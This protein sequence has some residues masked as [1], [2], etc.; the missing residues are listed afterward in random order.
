MLTKGYFHGTV[1][2]PPAR[3]TVTDACWIDMTRVLGGPIARKFSTTPAPDVFFSSIFFIKVEAD[4][5]RRGARR[6]PPFQEEARGPYFVGKSTRNKQR[7]TGL[8]LASKAAV[9]MCEMMGRP[10]SLIEKFQ[11]GHARQMG[12]RH[13]QDILRAQFP[14]TSCMP[15]SGFGADGPRG[16]N[17]G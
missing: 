10:T 11:A 14:R 12:W 7:S 17:R 9:R 3:V 1:A 16:G 15:L 2:A 4:R 6:G 5:R 13:R 8:D